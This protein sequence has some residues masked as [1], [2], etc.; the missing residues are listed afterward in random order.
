MF[1]HSETMLNRENLSNDTGD[2]AVNKTK[3]P[4]VFLPALRTRLHIT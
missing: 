1:F 2:R 3:D 4:Q